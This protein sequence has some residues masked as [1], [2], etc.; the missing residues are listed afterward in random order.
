M[1]NSWFFSH[2]IADKF[3]LLPR[4]AKGSRSINAAGST[5]HD[6][7]SRRG[8]ASQVARECEQRGVARA[9]GSD[10]AKPCSTSGHRT[11]GRR[12]GECGTH[13]RGTGSGGPREPGAV[14]QPGTELAG[15]QPTGSAAGPG[16]APPAA[17]A[18]QVPLHRLHQPGRVLHGPGGD[19]A[20]QVPHRERGD[21]ARRDEHGAAARRHP[22]AH[23]ADDGRRRALLVRRPPAAARRPPHPHPRPGRLRPG[24]Q[25]V[26]ERPL[27][28][29]HPSG[30]DPAGLRT[31]SRSSR[32]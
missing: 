19:A 5:A 1:R 16:R 3:A 21:V 20:A 28:P 24:S 9:A 2:P 11:D 15:V 14:H 17:R 23:Q 30:A 32:T 4:S 13:G 7:S 27:P 29:E 26:S 8:T 12:G 31:R 18:G 10:H 25:G 6:S 22:R